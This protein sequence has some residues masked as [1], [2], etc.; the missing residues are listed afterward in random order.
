[1][2]TLDDLRKF[3]GYVGNG[4][5]IGER[6]TRYFRGDNINMDGSERG[7]DLLSLSDEQ[8]QDEAWVFLTKGGGPGSLD[9]IVEPL[10]KYLAD[11]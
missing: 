8:R 7:F 4:Q 9:Q 11:R 1:M 5:V 3:Y 2:S 10:R 6:G